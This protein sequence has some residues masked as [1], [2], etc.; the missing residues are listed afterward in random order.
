MLARVAS[1]R[2]PLNP[3]LRLQC[4]LSPDG[5]W[6]ATPLVDGHTVNL[7][8]IPTDG[9]PMRAVTDFGQR[10]V[11]IVRSVAWSAD[12]TRIYAAVADANA[13]VFLLDGLIG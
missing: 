11:L 1:G 3:R 13:D 8:L 10:S 7:W 9:G 5:R 12:S 4:R 6:L 2:V